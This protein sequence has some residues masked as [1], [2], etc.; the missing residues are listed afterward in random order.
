MTRPTPELIAALRATALKL[1]D[2]ATYAWS[3]MGSCNCGHLAQTLTGLSS[4]S[5]QSLA[6]ESAG[7]WREQT[8]GYCGDTQLPLHLIFDA[9]LQAGMTTEDIIH[10]ERLSSPVVLRRLGSTSLLLD[11]RSRADVIRYMNAWADL[12]E[13][14]LLP[15]LDVSQAMAVPEPVA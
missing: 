9:M 15:Q 1:H 7:D 10:L 11:Y 8:E 3:R 6:H 14:A 4:A 12:L 5:I 2:G 13:E